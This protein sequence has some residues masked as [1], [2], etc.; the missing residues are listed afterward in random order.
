MGNFLACLKPL[1]NK[2]IELNVE[3]STNSRCCTVRKIY[4]VTSPEKLDAI[5]RIIRDGS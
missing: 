3:I 5:L 1:D 4:I 2:D